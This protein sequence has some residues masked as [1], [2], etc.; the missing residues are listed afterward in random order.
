M[1]RRVGKIH[2]IWVYLRLSYASG[3]DILYG[4]SRY[5]R[6]HAHWNIRLLPFSGEESKLPFPLPKDADGIISSEP[7]TDDAATSSIPLVVIG[8]REKWLGRRMRSLAF[9]RNDDMKIGLAAA[10]KFLLSRLF[11]SFGFVG[12]HVRNYCSVLREEGFRSGLGAG[13]D[14]RAYE[15]DKL[16]DGSPADIAALGRWL[17]SLPKPAAVMAVHD[18]RATH[19]ISAAND[20]GIAIPKELSII[21]VDN[22]ELL[23]EFTSPPLTSI[24]PDHIHEGELAAEVLHALMEGKTASKS[25]TT[26]KSC[27]FEIVERDTASQAS[28]SGNLAQEAMSFIRQNFK[29]GIRAEDVIRSVPGRSSRILNARFQEMYGC[30]LHEAILRIRYSELKRRLVRS[31][32]PI[33]EL[34]AACGFSDLSNAKRIFKSR[35]GMSMREW[36][37][38][39]K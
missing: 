31:K 8:T 37:N 26:R 29:S 22:D 17:A 34:M 14:I 30:S 9:V 33:G 24:A 5:A 2:K 3:R 18:L 36:R 39:T 7:L 21:G 19:V 4:I 1:K 27:R 11:A 25:H 23:C 28:L 12:S 38:V 32:A 10:K 6:S 16:V 20:R 35:F 15:Q 13:R